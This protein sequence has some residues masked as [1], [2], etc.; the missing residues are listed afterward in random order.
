MSRPFILNT[1]YALFSQLLLDNSDWASASL[2][3]IKNLEYF[4]RKHHALEYSLYKKLSS[5]E[6]RY[7]ASMNLIFPSQHLKLDDEEPQFHIS[8]V[9]YYSPSIIF[10]KKNKLNEILKFNIFTLQGNGI[11]DEIFQKDNVFEKVYLQLNKCGYTSLLTVCCAKKRKPICALFF[12]TIN[13]AETPYMIN[14]EI[15]CLQLYMAQARDIDSALAI[16]VDIVKNNIVYDISKQGIV[17]TRPPYDLIRF[18]NV[19]MDVVEKID[20]KINMSCHDVYKGLLLDHPFRY[21]V[22]VETDCD[23]AEIFYWLNLRALPDSCRL[24]LI[25]NSNVPYTQDRDRKQNL[26]VIKTNDKIFYMTVVLNN[27]LQQLPLASSKFL[28]FDDYFKKF[29]VFQLTDSCY[30]IRKYNTL[31]VSSVQLTAPHASNY[32]TE[33][34]P[35]TIDTINWIELSDIEQVFVPIESC[36]HVNLSNTKIYKVFCKDFYYF[37]FYSLHTKQ[38]SIEEIF[39]ELLET[40]NMGDE[41]VQTLITKLAPL[42]PSSSP[43]T[44]SSSSSNNESSMHTEDDSLA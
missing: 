16:D 35:T 18:K 17:M 11:F 22:A 36:V 43:T 7:S 32:I 2:T 15:E 1:K 40:A 10:A 39:N 37:V 8:S 38:L 27:P 33:T 19:L 26:M 30:H 3:R 24:H 9:F 14:D 21:I 29:Q 20:E 6:K 42:L 34:I 31:L 44:P 5:N 41:G 13:L 12:D 25:I 23:I 28:L 4:T